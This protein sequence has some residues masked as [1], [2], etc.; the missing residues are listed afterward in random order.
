VQNTRNTAGQPPI[1]LFDGVCNLCNAGV[2]FILKHESAPILRFAAMQSNSG[3][4]ILESN[5]IGQF[6]SSMILLENNQI[7]VRSTAV[8]LLMRY[9]RPPWRCLAWAILIPAPIRDWIYDWIA[10][11]RYG[12]FGKT[13]ECQLPTEADRSRFI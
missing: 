1:L 4:K 5:G 6:P 2:Q 13:E 3:R 10:T 7:Y 12:W 9:L 11:H 8:C